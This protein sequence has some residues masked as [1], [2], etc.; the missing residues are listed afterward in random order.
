[1]DPCYTTKTALAMSIL[2]MRLHLSWN[3]NAGSPSKARSEMPYF[4]LWT[5]FGLDT[6]LE[7]HPV[8][9]Q[10]DVALIDF[11]KSSSNTY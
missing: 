4:S 1:M 3:R 8:L 11:N 7:D 5:P 9:W 10:A 6:S 2:R